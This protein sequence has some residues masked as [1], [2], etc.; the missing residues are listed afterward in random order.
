MGKRTGDRPAA[1]R[2]KAWGRGWTPERR[3]QFIA[4]LAQTGNISAAARGVGYSQATE[5][6]KLRYG[7]PEFAAAW[8]QAIAE[9][10]ARVESTLVARALKEIE[11][12]SAALEKG[13]TP[14]AF[15]FDQMMRLLTYYRTVQGKPVR[16]G[17]QRRYATREETD[18]ALM[19]KLDVLEAQVKAREKR[20]A[21]ERRAARAAA[22][23]AAAKGAG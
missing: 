15:T 8:D 20:E 3:Q 6:Y 18:A 17:P 9:A 16:G 21:A 10:V 11:A 2:G 12:H 5:A 14:E 22:K 7:D 4:L 19:K 23:E 13:E 1:R